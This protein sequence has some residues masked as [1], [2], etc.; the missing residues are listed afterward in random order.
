MTVVDALRL[1]VFPEVRSVSAATPLMAAVRLQAAMTSR[2]TPAVPVLLVMFP[3]LTCSVVTD[4]VSFAVNVWLDPSLQVTVYTS[5][6]V[7]GVAI[8]TVPVVVCVAPPALVIVQSAGTVRV[9]TSLKATGVVGPLLM[10]VHWLVSVMGVPAEYGPALG[11]SVPQLFV[12]SA[13]VVIATIVEA[14]PVLLAALVS[15][16]CSVVTVTVSFAVNVWL[17][18]LV[19]E[20]TQAEG[21]AFAECR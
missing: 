20:T 18:G 16:T 4:T 7:V 17:D 6:T 19:Q 21:D 2:F 8:V 13:N 14:V 5:V 11:V 10:M 15:V 9:V 12:R 1:A 3:S